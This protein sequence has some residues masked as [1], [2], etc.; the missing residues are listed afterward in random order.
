[1][2][3]LPNS[4][5]KPGLPAAGARPALS[6]H[7]PLFIFFGLSRSDNFPF[8]NPPRRNSPTGAPGVFPRLRP[9]GSFAPNLA[10]GARLRCPG[11][12]P[13]RPPCR[14][15]SHARGGRGGA[16]RCAHCGPAPRRPRS[17]PVL[18]QE[19]TGSYRIM[20]CTV[21]INVIFRRDGETYPKG[22]KEGNIL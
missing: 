5:S 14:G 12:P 20:L 17:A 11:L 19:L 21:S 13:R 15:G 16:G 4:E 18:W 10:P 1:M 8:Y 3:G 2:T 6:P 22:W 9:C 7:H